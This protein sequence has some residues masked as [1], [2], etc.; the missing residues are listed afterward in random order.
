MLARV[1]FFAPAMEAPLRTD[2]HT[3]NGERPPALPDTPLGKAGKAGKS[4]LGFEN[5]PMNGVQ[6][7]WPGWLPRGK[8]TLLAG[9][10][11]SGKGTLAAHLMACATNRRP[12]PDGSVSE[13]C[14]TAVVSPDDAL[15]DTLKPRLHFSGVDFELCRRLNPEAGAIKDL[16]SSSGVG[17]IVL[18]MVEAGMTLGTDGNAAGDVGRHL[19]NFNRLAED[20]NAAVLVVHHVN[21][22]VR[23]KVG[24][25]SLAN[26]VRGSGAWTDAVRMAWLMA[27]DEN[28]EDGGRVLVRAKCNVGGVAWYRDG[29]RISSRNESYDGENGLRGMTTVVDTVT[30]IKGSTHDIFLAAVVKNEDDAPRITK[31]DQC[32]DAIIENME[33]GV[34]MLKTD[35][36]RAL[37]AQGHAD[38]TIE[39]AADVMRHTEDLNVRKVTADEFPEANRNAVVWELP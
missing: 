4:L 6:W 2:N 36:V 14:L 16:R 8:T 33:M 28:D 13:P 21:K 27:V 20:L 32:R 12:W 25:G 30:P 37:R 31:Q 24:E 38:R 23:L 5:V 10:G 19:S 22:W 26:L 3:N 34:P 1:Q 7:L 35:V 11:G 39:R 9:A 15:A 17:L 29:Y 18:D